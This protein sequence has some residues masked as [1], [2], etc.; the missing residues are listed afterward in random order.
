MYNDGW[1]AASRPD[2][3]PWDMSPETLAQFGPLSDWDPDRDV[4]WELY[5]LPDDFSQAKNVAA[6]HPDK[7][8]SCKS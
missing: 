3:I 5:Y 2:R 1:W 8:L 7:V 6:Q 4:G